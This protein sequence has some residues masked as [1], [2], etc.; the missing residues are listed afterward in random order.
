MAFCQVFWRIPQELRY[1][2]ASILSLN[3]A[4]G[5]LSQGFAGNTCHLGD[6]RI[7]FIRGGRRSGIENRDDKRTMSLGKYDGN[8]VACA[9]RAAARFIADNP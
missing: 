8:V 2:P 1:D 6:D 4:Y 3:A 7:F 5:L 9:V